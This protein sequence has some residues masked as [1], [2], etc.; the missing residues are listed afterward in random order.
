MEREVLDL[1]I[2]RCLDARLDPERLMEI[3]V[4]QGLRNQEEADEE[5]EAKQ[6]HPSLDPF[7]DRQHH[8]LKMVVAMASCSLGVNLNSNCSFEKTPCNSITNWGYSRRVLGFGSKSFCIVQKKGR[9]RPEF[10]GTRDEP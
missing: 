8:Q 5:D 4:P 1:R 3:A 2:K 6:T 9:T 7:E 10:P